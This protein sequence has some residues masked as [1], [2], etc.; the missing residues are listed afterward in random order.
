MPVVPVF[1]GASTGSVFGSAR[2]L[3]RQ[4]DVL[5]SSGAIFMRNRS[6]RL[7][8]ML[9]RALRVAWCVDR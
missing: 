5:S 6:I 9:L 1:P 7:G 8:D 3:Y 2:N 4:V